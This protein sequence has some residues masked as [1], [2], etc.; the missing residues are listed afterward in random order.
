MDIESV[1]GF[2]LD[3]GG[4][5]ASFFSAMFPRPEQV[6]LAEI[7]YKKAHQAKQ[8]QPSLYV[9]VADGQRLP[10]SDRSVEATVCNSVIEHVNCPG[11]FA[12]E[13]RRVSKRF[14]LQTPNVSFPFEFHSYIPIPLFHFI[15]FTWLRR[16]VSRMFGGNF[17][18]INSVK[19]VS[20]R[21]L[22]EFFPEAQVTRESFI[23]LTK[24]FYVQK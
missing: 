10:L 16:F 9:V 22:K 13:I 12:A 20:E 19:Y 7:D 18:Y 3:L 5:P 15:P 23:G 17:D 21:Q 14:F 6:I 2:I 24:S 8:K 11:L 4:G 1:S